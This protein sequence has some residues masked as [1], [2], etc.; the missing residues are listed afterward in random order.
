MRVR[1]RLKGVNPVRRKLAD[2]T[3]KLYPYYG[4]G[5]GAIRL[6]GGWDSPEDFALLVVSYNRAKAERRKGDPEIFKGIITAFMLSPAFT[7]L[8]ERTRASYQRIIRKIE[9][10]FGDLPVAALN[11]EHV[12]KDFLDW[13]D[14]MAE[15]PCQADYAW[16]VLMRIISW[17]RGRA[18]TTYR[19]PERVEALYYSDRSDLIWEDHHIAAFNAVAPKPLQWALMMAAETGLRQGD[20]ALLPWSAYDDK[21]DLPHAPLGWIRT[22]PSKS[23]TRRRPKGRAVRIPVTRRLRALLD[24]LWALRSKRIVV[25]RDRSDTILT[26]SDGR[27]WK[28]AKTL[29]HR[30]G[31]ASDK[32]GI[33]GLHF[34]DLRGTAVTRLNEAGCTPQEIQP[35]TGHTLESIHRILERYGAHTD[36]LAGAAIH[37]LEKHRG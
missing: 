35:I 18:M 16:R 8:R 30:F 28:N 33:E 14:S 3:V 7:K 9:D 11:D 2:G 10:K 5:R 1:L 34:H 29:S 4:R 20:L 17:A 36:A 32:A 13:R 19:P 23:I 15:T 21:P 31:A 27:P 26:N 37:K 25:S 24:E 22:V 6:E 12:T